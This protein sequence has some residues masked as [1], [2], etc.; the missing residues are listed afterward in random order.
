[1]ASPTFTGTVTIPAGASIS[2][3]LTSSTAAS[4][5]APLASPALTGNPTAPTP[6]TSDNDTSIATTAFVN[7]FVPA[8]STT[9][10]GKVELATDAETRTG[11][12]TSL[13][14]TPSGVSSLRY[15]LNTDEQEFTNVVWLTATSGGGQASNQRLAKF[16]NS[17]TTTGYGVVY[18]DL[19][20]SSIGNNASS[21][22]DW[23]KKQVYSCRVTINPLPSDDNTVLRIQLGKN[24]TSSVAGD[25]SVRG[26]GIKM[27]GNNDMVLMAHDGTTLSTSTTSFKPTANQCFELR[28]E[29]N[30]SGSVTAFVNNSSIGTVTGGPTTR[31]SANQNGVYLENQNL[32]S[33][34][35]G[36]QLY[37]SAHRVDFGI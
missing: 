2:G 14:T 10:A 32:G 9:V 20:N 7:A 36:S 18:V 34:T 12:S 21:A 23:S 8:A 16:M 37:T 6:D 33:V 22:I 1:L 3:F 29:S 24:I 5:Y 17:F 25:I 28:L 27:T 31:G 19:T 4:T 13:A 15:H 35:T 11:T 26:I 30:G